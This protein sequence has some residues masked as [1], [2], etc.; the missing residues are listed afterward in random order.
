MARKCYRSYGKNNYFGAA[1][2]RAAHR[3][4][5]LSREGLGPRHPNRTSRT[6]ELVCRTGLPACPR[7]ECADVCVWCGRGDLNP[8]AL[9][10]AA[11]SRLCVCQFRHFRVLKRYFFAGR[12]RYRRYLHWTLRVV[13]VTGGRGIWIVL[14]E[15]CCGVTGTGA[16]FTGMDFTWAGLPGPS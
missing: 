14:L 2:R 7:A 5:H 1:A 12:S 11:T 15:A 13:L 9:T 6:L 4:C 16:V 3:Y 10:G 8:H